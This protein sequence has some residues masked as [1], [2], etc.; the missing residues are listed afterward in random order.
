[1]AD[2]TTKAELIEQIHAH[3]A[4]LDAATA[5]I[6]AAQMSVPGVN[7]AWSVKDTIAHLT[8]WHQ[9][10][11]ARLQSAAT[12]P[13]VSARTEIDDDVWNLRCFVANR[14]RALDDVMADL[15]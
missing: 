2:P 9:N 14:D 13:H 12:N 1:M 6:L 15:W 7:G 3:Y 8:F 4:A 11:L 10:L 5:P